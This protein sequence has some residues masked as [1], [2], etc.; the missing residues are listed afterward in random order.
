MSI[1]S[2][3][4]FVFDSRIVSVRPRKSAATAVPSFASSAYPVRPNAASALT[5]RG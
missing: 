3:Y 2:P 5:V 1:R 4:T